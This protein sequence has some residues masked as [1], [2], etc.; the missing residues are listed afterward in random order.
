M[1]LKR[2]LEDMNVGETV[3]FSRTFTEIDVTQF[4]GMTWDVN[5]YHT[6]DEFCKTHRVGRR[7]VPGL[8]VGSMLTHVGGLAAVLATH[9]D[10]EFIAPVFIGDT[11]TIT[12]VVDQADDQRGWVRLTMTGQTQDE[13]LVTRASVSGYPA[14]LR[15]RV[16][17]RD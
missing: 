14:R 11:V 4:V 3:V 1:N 6:D 10:F 5:P 16:K 13:R 2:A 8:L 15:D 9:L 7:I 17:A 12:C